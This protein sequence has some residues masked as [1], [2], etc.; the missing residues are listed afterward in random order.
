MTQHN[1]LGAGSFKKMT[2][3]TG[4]LKFLFIFLFLN[5]YLSKIIDHA[6]V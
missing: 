5:Q 3:N 2:Y 4:K 6:F 1:S